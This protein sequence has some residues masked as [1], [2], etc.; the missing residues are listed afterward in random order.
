MAS[1]RPESRWNTSFALS[2]SLR[3]TSYV[4]TL[5]TTSPAEAAAIIRHGGLVAFPTET[6]YG[7]GADIFN[8]AA[9]AKIFE[10]KGR[11]ADNP[12]IVHIAAVRQVRLL[13]NDLTPAAET[14]LRAFAPG[15]ITVVVPRSPKVPL[16]ATAGLETIG[17]RMPRL[18]MAREFLAAC[19]V[20]VAAPSANISGRPSPTTWQAVQEDLDGRIDCILQGTDSEIGLESTVVDC[21]VEPPVVLRAGSVT[22]EQLQ[23]VIP[24]T[25]LFSASGLEAPR[26]PGLKHQ[27][28]SPRA[29][30]IIGA[31]AVPV[32]NSAF[33]GI[34]KPTS[35]FC[36]SRVCKDIE[37]YGRSIYEF[38]RECDRAG[39][40]TI[41]CEQVA[42][43]GIGVAL[44]D[45]IRRAAEAG[46]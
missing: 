45:R 5:L 42:E 1:V 36:Y 28:Y 33:I 14:L 29:R 41:Y 26:S 12:L 40:E 3:K 21:T 39:I 19:N 16:I 37:E 25:K 7:L 34:A 15:P 13:T 22:L 23:A 9:I 17:I 20:P 35:E 32:D 10:A 31:P 46:G 43:S 2:R 27:H 8:E 11:P 38:F 44:I 18:P 6:V 24:G 30:V 4:N